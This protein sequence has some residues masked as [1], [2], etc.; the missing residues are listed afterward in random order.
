MVLTVENNVGKIQ[1]YFAG[2][3]QDPNWN[4]DFKSLFWRGLAVP[5]YVQIHLLP[6]PVGFDKSSEGECVCL[7]WLILTDE[8]F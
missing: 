7:I 6:C 3:W 5:A 2:L 8:V 4:S 1:E